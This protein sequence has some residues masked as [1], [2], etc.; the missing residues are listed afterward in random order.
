MHEALSGSGISVF[1]PAF[2]DEGTIGAMVAEALSLLPT[3]TDD[4]EVIVVNDGSTDSTPRVLDELARRHSHVR[5]IHHQ[6]N[7][8]YG[9]ALRSGFGSAGKGLIFYTDGD[10]QYD[11]RELV[12]L[13]PLMT[14]SVDVVN[15]YKIKRSDDLRRVV[16]GWIYRRLARLL[17]RLPVRDVDCDFRLIRKDAIGKVSLV[18]SSGIICTEM[19]RKLHAAGCV[20][21]EAPVHHYPRRHGQSQ[22]FTL[23]RVMRTA[24]DFGL[25]W[26]KL[27]VWQPVR[28]QIPTA[29]LRKVLAHG[30]HL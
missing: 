24:F 23:G 9:A 7:L 1:F 15:G 17:F 16:L 11:V 18:S 28:R 25:L 6:R 27:F 21:T 20:F 4:Y 5:V 13:L 3:L 29:W 12:N 8:G 10:G 30:I 22:F 14:P 19:V 2:N 26:L